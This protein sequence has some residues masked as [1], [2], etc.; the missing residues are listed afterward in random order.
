MNLR[1][2]LLTLVSLI[3]GVALVALLAV[4]SGVGWHTFVVSLGTIDPMVLGRLSLLFALNT[5]LSSM[6]WRL[7]DRVVRGPAD[8][9]LPR[10]TAFALTSI[11]VALG[12]VLPIQLSMSLARTLGTWVYGRAL[13]RGTLGTLFEQA[14]DF[15]IL[16]FLTVASAS[17]RLLHG[18]AAMWL[19][20]ALFMSLFAV[21]GVGAV[22]NSVR[23]LT[24]H[25]ASNGANL[26]R[27]RRLMIELHQSGLLQPHLARQLMAI[28]T[29]RFAVLVLM[30]SQT[31]AAIHA[32]IPLWHL[33][34]TIPFA[35]L[36]AVVGITPGGLGVTEF[37]YAAVLSL[38]GTPLAVT[39][40]WAIANR[41]LSSASAFVIATIGSAVLFS[42]KARQRVP[43][44]HDTALGVN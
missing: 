14:F 13:R 21:W 12:Q 37:T 29:I 4:A 34:A 9:A 22:M 15:L 44:S 39:T 33:A 18:G 2:V 24:T 7:T 25:I 38:F 8:A 6:K 10:S 30:A 16:C 31:T 17:T 32:D 26:A 3:L 28:S 35:L 23:R 43:T 19:A 40:Q 1:S 5:Y 27:W 11:G 36:A 41:L 42:D 20:S